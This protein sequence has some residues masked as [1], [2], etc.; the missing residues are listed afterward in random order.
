MAKP[1]TSAESLHSPT[2]RSKVMAGGPASPS[3]DDFQ[4]I[5]REHYAAIWRFLVHLGVRKSD[6]PDVTHNVFMI[7]HRKLAEFEHRST[8]RTWLCGIALRVGRDFLRSA[9]VRLEVSATDVN[10][11]EAPSGDDSAEALRQ[12]RQLALA[13]RLLDALPAEQREVFVLHELEQMTGSE[14]ATLMGTPINTV[15][16]RLKR[17]RDSFRRQLAELKLEGAVDV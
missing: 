15:R 10:L 5:Y 3:L 9:A 11:P 17:A 8:V 7:A 14:I 12:K 4:A 2:E 1:I 13:V 6:V 16:S